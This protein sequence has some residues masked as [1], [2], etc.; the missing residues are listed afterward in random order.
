VY[1]SFL[2]EHDADLNYTC[3]HQNG[4][5]AN[6]QVSK[7]RAAPVEHPVEFF[8]FFAH[9]PL[10]GPPRLKDGPHFT[11]EPGYYAAFWVAWVSGREAS[12]PRQSAS[13]PPARLVMRRGQSVRC[14]LFFNFGQ[15][16]RPEFE[17]QLVD[18]AGELERQLV[19]VIHPRASIEPNIE[20]L[21]NG[22]Q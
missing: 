2:Q 9:A 15:L 3:E 17:G 8:T 1:G 16:R 4:G 6:I 12:A 22:H 11:I 13:V 14:G 20:G 18:R 19:A 7:S 5:E 10:A 21:I